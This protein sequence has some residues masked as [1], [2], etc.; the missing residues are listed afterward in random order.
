MV[1]LVNK[2]AWAADKVVFSPDGNFLVSC[3]ASPAFKVVSLLSNSEYIL[4]ANRTG[5]LV[6]I[7]PDNRL[8]IT[9]ERDNSSLQI[10]NI[11]NGECVAWLSSE[12]Y[13]EYIMNFNLSPNGRLV[14]S[15]HKNGKVYLR[16]IGKLYPDA[17]ISNQSS[18][19]TSGQGTIKKYLTALLSPFKK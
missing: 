1:H 13:D 3:G 17:Q 19:Q 14:A 11:S 4:N 18:N 6:A 15:G 10:W 8:L 2:H 5:Y 16:Q 12:S 7:S 9:G